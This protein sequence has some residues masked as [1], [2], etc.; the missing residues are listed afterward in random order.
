[1]LFCCSQESNLVNLH[2]CP[3]K[4]WAKVF[5]VFS[6][7]IVR[8]LLKT[9]L[10]TLDSVVLGAGDCSSSPS[11]FPQQLL[12]FLLGD[13]YKPKG[14]FQGSSL[15]RSESLQ[16]APFAPECQRYHHHPDP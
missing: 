2:S 10:T 3:C 16:A 1:M 9:G 8:Y 7:Q 14:W 6:N 12:I 5:H 4:Q 11:P 15:M 13:F